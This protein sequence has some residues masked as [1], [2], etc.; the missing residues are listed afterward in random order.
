MISALVVASSTFVSCHHGGDDDETKEYLNGTLS[1]N[2]PKYLQCGDVVHIE[3]TGVYRNDES[4]TML[5]CS[6]TNPFTNKTD[7]IRLESDPAAKGKD[8]DFE[9]SADSLSTFTIIVSVWADG[10]YTKTTS[11]TFTVVDPTLGTGSLKGYDFLGAVSKMTD[12]R[13]GSE[14][15]YC[16]AAGK[17]W[18]IQN[19]AWNG[20]GISYVDAEALDHIFGRFYTWDEAVSAC[21]AG[22]H[23]PSS[24][25]FTAIAGEEGAGNLMVNASFNGTTMWEFWP[26]VK[27]TNGSRF[28][29]IPVGYVSVEGDGKSFIGMNSYALFWTSD[30]SEKMAVA[31]YIYVDKPVLYAGEF[32]KAGICASVRCV[33]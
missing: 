2:V 19:L 31:R 22:W 10:Y 28:S 27:I 7:T 1:I 30:S 26:A 25:D 21:P 5:C 8:F 29:A 9:V 6:W 20:S 33:R 15:Y 11:A 18:L 24:A 3:P 14:Y 17:D 23:L 12:E 16:N 32:D 4:D 13:D